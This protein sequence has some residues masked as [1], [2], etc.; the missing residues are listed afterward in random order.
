MSVPELELRRGPRGQDGG[1]VGVEAEVGED[2]H[3]DRPLGDEGHE[4]PLG[5]TRRATPTSSRGGAG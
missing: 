3:D 4:P 5:A 2:A 1:R